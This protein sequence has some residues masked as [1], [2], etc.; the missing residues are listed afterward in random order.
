[1][2]LNI[3][4]VGLMVALVSTIVGLLS[5]NLARK[6]EDKQ[7]VKDD[8]T[9]VTTLINKVD[10]FEKELESLKAK[11]NPTLEYIKQGV[12]DIK[13]EIKEIKADAKEREDKTNQKINSLADKVNE[14]AVK[15]ATV[16]ASY[17]SEH[18]RLNEMEIRLNEYERK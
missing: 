17:K 18:K 3:A 7:E 5:Y 2:E 1:M 16:E 4:N 9:M 11:D 10:F 8:T 15:Y 6:K 12:D 14:L 13:T